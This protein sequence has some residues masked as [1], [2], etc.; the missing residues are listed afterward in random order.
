MTFDSILV[1][2]GALELYTRTSGN[3]RRTTPGQA[4]EESGILGAERRLFFD[5]KEVVEWLSVAS[6]DC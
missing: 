5:S 2:G 4:F 1:G 6:L 3:D